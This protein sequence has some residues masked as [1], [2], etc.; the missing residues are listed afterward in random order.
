MEKEINSNKHNTNTEVPVTALMSLIAT[1]NWNCGVNF[2][3]CSFIYINVIR[4]KSKYR[5]GRFG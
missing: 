2:A 1:N 4:L 5:A 3:F